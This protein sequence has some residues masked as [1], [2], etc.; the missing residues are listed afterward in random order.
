[1]ATNKEIVSRVKNQFNS[2]TKDTDKSN[3]FILFTAKNIAESYISKRLN[4]K[5]L[6]RQDSLY[7]EI[8]CVEMES[9]NKYKCDIIEFRSCEKVAKSKFKLPSLIYSKLGNT[10]KEVTSIDGRYLFK[11]ST[12]AQFRRNSKR[13]KSNVQTEFF[14]VKDGYLYIPDSEVKMVNIYVLSLDLYELEEIS[15]CSEGC[16]SAWDYEFIV[17]SD[18]LEQ[19][20][21]ETASIVQTSVQIP[22]DESPNL[23]NRI[24]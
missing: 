14:Y 21:R 13:K 2:T 7:T 11:P 10:V 4:D 22:E 5:R 3:R 8:T 6:F 24:R 17:P 9:V 19:V 23:E 12:V 20:L 16:K 15:N 1:M 18:L